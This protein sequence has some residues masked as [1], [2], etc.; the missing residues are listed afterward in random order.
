LNNQIKKGLL[1]SLPVKKIGGHVHE[2]TTFFLI[3]NFA[4]YS[5]IKKKFA[6][7]QYTFLNLTPPHTTLLFI[8]NRFFSDINLHKVVWQHTQSVVGFLITIVLQIYNEIIQ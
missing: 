7:M 8:A 6:G 1:L 3:R 2:T 4:K 5:P